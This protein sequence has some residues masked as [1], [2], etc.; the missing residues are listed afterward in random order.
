MK[1]F[2]AAWRS[3]IPEVALAPYLAPAQADAEAVRLANLGGFE[4]VPY[5]TSA[6]GRPL[7]AVRVPSQKAG[8][9]AVLCSANIHGLEFIGRHVALGL[10][11]A[12][13]SLKSGTTG[14]GELARLVKRAELWV[15]PCLNPDGYAHTWSQAGRG[16]F[17]GL[18]T[19]AQQVDLNRNFPVPAGAM[20]SRLPGAGSK[21]RGDATY[22]GPSPLSE[23]ESA[24]LVQLLSRVPFV[25]STNLHSTMGALIP[26][27]VT[28]EASYST[29]KHLCQAF[30][31]AQKHRR[32]VRLA[33]RWLDVFTGELEDFQHHAF[34]TWT[35]C[36]EIFPFW[37]RLRQHLFAPSLF[38]R[39][40]P[41]SPERWIEN[42]VP[43]IVAFFHAVLDLLE[44]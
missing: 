37:E 41:P 6:E 17:A 20:L 9:P 44:R 23:P 35:V 30:R 21:R 8:A 11:A 15:I 10:L 42:D 25:A 22:R 4:L 38:W 16:R 14:D 39:F 7:T 31:R 29:Y 43:G 1:S 34:G 3:T 13:S 2:P 36:V 28:D 24:A 5:G 40:N 26:A 32:Y 33:H 18:R 19:N 12:T 27:H